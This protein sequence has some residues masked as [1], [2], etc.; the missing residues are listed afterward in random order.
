MTAGTIRV[1]GYLGK[2]VGGIAGL[3]IGGPM[4]AV[5]GAVAGH[6]YDH[7]RQRERAAQAERRRTTPRHE[8]AERHEPGTSDFDGIFADP[9]ETRRIA[10]ATAIIVLGAKLAKADGVV[11]QEEIRAF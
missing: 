7:W 3:A 2:I 5:I 11:S 10:F 9:A 8:R 1:T 6:A 4:G